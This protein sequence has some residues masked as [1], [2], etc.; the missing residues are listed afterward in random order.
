MIL[1]VLL[2]GCGL[3]GM[4]MVLWKLKL[5]LELLLRQLIAVMSSCRVQDCRKE[6]SFPVVIESGVLF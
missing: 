5:Q 6:N 3:H 4:A 2:A 1:N